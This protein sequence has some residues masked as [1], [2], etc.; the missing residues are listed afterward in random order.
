MIRFEL[1]KL[2]VRFF[3]NKRRY[4]SQL[5]A[6][7]IAVTIADSLQEKRAEKIGAD[8]PLRQFIA[9]QINDCRDVDALEAILSYIRR[10]GL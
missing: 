2:V 8:E 4:Q 9:E 7:A 10:N 3:G 1:R 5:V 6:I